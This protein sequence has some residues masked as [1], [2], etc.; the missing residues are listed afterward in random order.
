MLTKGYF[1]LDGSE[2]NDQCGGGGDVCGD[3]D[4][5]DDVE[6]ADDDDDDHGD[7]DVSDDN[8]VDKEGG[9][10]TGMCY[11]KTNLLACLIWSYSKEM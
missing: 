6:G 3:D 11:N 10:A 5:I 7:D 2:N 4:D 1:H 9:K 8:F